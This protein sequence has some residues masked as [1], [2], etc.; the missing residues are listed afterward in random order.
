MTTETPNNELIIFQLARNNESYTCAYYT[1]YNM[2][3][4]TGSGVCRIYNSLAGG[5]GDDRN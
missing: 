3:V 2:K 5:G 1:I 4:Y